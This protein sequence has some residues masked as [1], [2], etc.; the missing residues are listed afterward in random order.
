MDIVA[1]ILNPS[2]PSSLEAEVGGVQVQGQPGLQREILFQKTKKSGY[3]KQEQ[4]V[5]I[6]L[7]KKMPLFRP[8]FLL[9]WGRISLL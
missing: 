7:L 5:G 8:T 9:L 6:I 1:H 2:N 4:K 3:Y